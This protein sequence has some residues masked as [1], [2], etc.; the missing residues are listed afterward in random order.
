M[1]TMQSKTKH[2]TGWGFVDLLFNLLVGFTFMFLIAFLLINPVAKKKDF[3]PKAEF[4]LILTWNDKSDK[5]IDMWVQDSFNNIVSF[6][7]KDL[8]L[9]T[10][11]RDDLGISNDT[12]INDQGE[13]IERRVN[14]EVIS[15]KTKDP[16][17][18]TVTVHLYNARGGGDP[19]DNLSTLMVNEKVKVELIRV[20]P[21]S[22]LST[23]K[24]ELTMQ[25][26][27]KHIFEV[28]VVNDGQVQINETGKLIANNPERMKKE[29]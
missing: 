16:R 21:W 25:G 13:V 11:D 2:R 23:K 10:L 20:N 26:Q 29:W 15:I 8:A 7:A 22:L 18:Y 1:L 14:R 6:R 9:I 28:N 5:D 24:V 19:E 12:I 4:L 3:D 17:K 27:E